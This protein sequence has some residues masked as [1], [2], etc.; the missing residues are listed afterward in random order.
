MGLKAI[1]KQ[2]IN[3]PLDNRRKRVFFVSSHFNLPLVPAFFSF[4]CFPFIQRVFHQI[5]LKNKNKKSEFLRFVSEMF[6]N[7]ISD[8]DISECEKSKLCQ[9][10]TI[11][12]TLDLIFSIFLEKVFLDISES[13]L[14]KKKFVKQLFSFLFFLELFGQIFTP[15][16]TPLL[17]QVQT[18]PGN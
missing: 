17:N 16:Q 15:P 6:E 4:S 10:K 3:E 18:R 7:I 9:R 14:K 2:Q 11:Q 1:I 8:K 12:K 5:K 13:D